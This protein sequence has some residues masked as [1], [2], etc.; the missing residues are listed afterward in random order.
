MHGIEKNDFHL[1]PD[2]L[3]LV[4]NIGP[5]A[6]W[7]TRLLALLF[8]LTVPSKQESKNLITIAIV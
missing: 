8:S 2:Y 7:E 5:G 3:K 4:F 1:P 6:A